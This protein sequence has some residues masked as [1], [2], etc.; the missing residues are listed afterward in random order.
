MQPIKQENPLGCAV[1]CV[2]CI[3]NSSYLNSLNFFKNGKNKADN[4]GFLCKDIVA[5]LSKAGLNYEYRYIKDRIR[6]KIYR[7]NTIVFLKRSKRYPLGHY[8]CRVHHKWMDP[9][10]NL[11]NEKIKSGYRAKLPEKPIYAIFRVN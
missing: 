11:P 7:H 6:N 5:A 4:T 10:I 8:L 2:A 1:A 9:W 3:I